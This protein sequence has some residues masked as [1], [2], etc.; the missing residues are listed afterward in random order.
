[1][2]STS[3]TTA[4]HKYVEITD[5]VFE[6]DEYVE[7]GLDTCYHYVWIT[8]PSC[9]KIDYVWNNY[10]GD[11]WAIKAVFADDGITIKHFE[12]DTTV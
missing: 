2:S 11:Q 8:N 6:M 4:A 1:M 9:D 5:I 3:T 7:S 10:C 12:V